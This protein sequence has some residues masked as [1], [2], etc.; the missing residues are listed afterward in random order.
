MNETPQTDLYQSPTKQ[1]K[2]SLLKQCT[3]I[4]KKHWKIALSYLLF[5][6]SLIY[7]FTFIIF[8]PKRNSNDIHT[9]QMLEQSLQEKNTQIDKLTKA[10]SQR[11]LIIKERSTNPSP[12]YVSNPTN[13]NETLNHI[14]KMY[15]IYHNVKKIITLPTTPPE[16][17]Q[18]T[19]QTNPP[20]GEQK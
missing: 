11:P 14:I 10:L 18:S 3:T 16:S 15:E 19:D 7:L 13:M 2:N 5:I 8:T 6:T 9:I 1:P 17:P 12:N 20:Q 4:C